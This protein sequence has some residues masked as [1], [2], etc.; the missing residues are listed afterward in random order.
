MGGVAGQLTAPV[1]SGF[2]R[3]PSGWFLQ[4]LDE[5]SALMPSAIQKKQVCEGRSD[6]PEARDSVAR[7][8]EAGD[9]K[10]EPLPELPVK[11]G[12][13]KPEQEIGTTEAE[14]LPGGVK[15]RQQPSA[16]F[17]RGSRK[18]GRS[19]Q[20]SSSK[21]REKKHPFAL[22]GWGERQT[23]TGSQKTHN[24]CASAPVHEIHESALRAKNR[25]QVEKRRLVA[26]RQRAHSAEA[27]KGR[28]LR[29]GPAESPWVT[30]Y[31]RCYSA[32]A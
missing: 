12:K 18:A 30:E 6:A 21:I 31:M 7:D 10:D 25:R 4:S 27:E 28:R 19:P 14:G 29:P 3:V 1:L 26:Q 13:E 2:N 8:A 24:V 15:P 9:A 16:L 32:R 5:A 11:D 23:D 22:Y 20:R 17:A